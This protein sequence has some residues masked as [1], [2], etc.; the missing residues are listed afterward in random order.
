MTRFTVS[1]LPF[2]GSLNP[3]LGINFAVDGQETCPAHLSAI[4]AHFFSYTQDYVY[5]RTEWD[6]T[7]SSRPWIKVSFG[8]R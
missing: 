5:D 4:T 6:N 3:E 2:G 7:D 8:V 1:D